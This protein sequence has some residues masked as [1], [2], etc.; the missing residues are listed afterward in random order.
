MDYAKIYESIITRAKTRTL[1][2][3]KESHHI[4]PKCVGGSNHSSNLVDL[5]AEEH[6]IAHLLLVKLY[7]GNKAMWYAANMM[8]NRNN[9]H[10]AWTRKRHAVIVSEDKTGFK[11]SDL[12]KEKMRRAIAERWANDADGFVQE[13][14]RRASHPKKKKDGYFKPKSNEHSQNI[15]KAALQRPRFPCSICGKLITKA[16][17]KNHMKV[18]K[19]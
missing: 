6:Y 2:G 19:E 13:Q 18:H 15:S 1:D 4:V 16:N 14:K 12:A 11:H 3:Y 17:I 10:Y 8:S 9:K 7:P 5:T